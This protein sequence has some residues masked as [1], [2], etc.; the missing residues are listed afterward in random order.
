VTVERKAL[1]PEE[2]RS[3]IAGSTFVWHQSFELVPGVETPGAHPL[4]Y[5]FEVGAVPDDLRGKR[6]LDLGTSNGGAAFLMERRG[7]ARVVAVDIYPPD[8]FGFDELRRFLGS[9][10]EYFQGTVYELSRL[11]GGETFDHVLFWG[12]LY[13]LRHPLLALDQVRSVLAPDGLVEIES[14]VA[15]EELGACGELPVSR[16]YRR[17]ELAADPSNWFSPTVACLKDWCLSSGLVPERVEVW[18]D[19]RRCMVVARRSPGEP[20]FAQISYE[21]PLQ[22]EPATY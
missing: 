22:A 18:G 9:D 7:A 6:V 2:A 16:F 11:V 1:A 21:V 20:E 3:F 14:A 15:D 4:D 5:L 12:V 19:G 17:N 10:V 13:H 8:W